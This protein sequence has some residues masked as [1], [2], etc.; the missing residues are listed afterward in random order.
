M[1]IWPSS[2]FPE[3]PTLRQ[4]FKGKWFPWKV[5]PG[6]QVGSPRVSR[7]REAANKKCS[8]KPVTTVDH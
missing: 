3:K 6:D 4:S 7:G 5:I 8:M 1:A 2:G